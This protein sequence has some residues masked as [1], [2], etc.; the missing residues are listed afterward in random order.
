MEPIL[1]NIIA[2]VPH[3]LGMFQSQ[4]S[5][6]WLVV[7]VKKLLK[8]RPQYIT[9]HTDTENIICQDGIYLLVV[10]IVVL[11]DCQSHSPSTTL[12]ASLSWLKIVGGIQ[13]R[14][15]LPG[16]VDPRV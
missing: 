16:V 10:L 5:M 6:I 3:I 12:L 15:Q 2:K 1:Y 7:L 4:N 8:D 9:G 14:R 11:V 13:W